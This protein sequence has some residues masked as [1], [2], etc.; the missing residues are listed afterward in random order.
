VLAVTLIY[1]TIRMIRNRMDLPTI[2]FL[3][4]AFVVLLGIGP[5]PFL[6]QLPLI[7]NIVRPFITNIL[8]S[9]GARGILIG[10]ALGSLVTGLR[11]LIGA[12]R[13]YGGK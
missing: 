1:A 10:V 8:A 11:V 7:S 4:T 13:P 2:I 5:W 12:D 6:G 3:V 9:G